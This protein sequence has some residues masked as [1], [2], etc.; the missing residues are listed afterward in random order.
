MGDRF[1]IIIDYNW[2]AGFFTGE[3]C[4]SVGIIKTTYKDNYRYQVCLRVIVAQHS[5]DK[6]LMNSLANTLKCG[7]VSKHKNNAVVLTIS[8]FKDIYNKIIPLFE[9]YNI[10]GVKAFDFPD[11]CRVVKLVN[12]KAHLISAGLE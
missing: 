2:I 5:R 8:I 12:K 1:S 7:I 6:L 4:F 9:E 3:C 11:F 10:K